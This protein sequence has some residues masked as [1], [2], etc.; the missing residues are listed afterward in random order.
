MPA[1]KKLKEKVRARMD[2]TGESYTE[3]RRQLVGEPGA[4]GDLEQGVRVGLRLA[5]HYARSNASEYVLA[6]EELPQGRRAL[7]ARATGA[8]FLATALEQCSLEHDADAIAKLSDVADEEFVRGLDGALRYASQL[9]GA[10]ERDYQRAGEGD[11]AHGA[12]SAMVALSG[13]LTAIRTGR[14]PGA[15]HN[16]QSSRLDYPLDSEIVLQLQRHFKASTAPGPWK[17]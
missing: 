3:A 17:H 6:A 12:R 5:A 9:V 7:E 13:A 2:R 11:H 1:K 8:T 14:S 16:H 15:F 10:V 4:E